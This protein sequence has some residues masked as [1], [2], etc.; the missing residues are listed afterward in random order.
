MI[1]QH[2]VDMVA[3]HSI[4][5]FLYKPKFLKMSLTIRRIHHSAVKTVHTFKLFV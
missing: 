5:K 1:L 2:F 3:G 4:C